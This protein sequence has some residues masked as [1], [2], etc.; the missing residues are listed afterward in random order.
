MRTILMS[1]LWLQFSCGPAGSDFYCPSCPCEND[2]RKHW[3]LHQT[4]Q[5][6]FQ[7]FPT[8]LPKVLPLL[9]TNLTR[10]KNLPKKSNRAAT[11]KRN[12]PLILTSSGIFSHFVWRSSIECRANEKFRWENVEGMVEC[13]KVRRSWE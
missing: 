3:I 13:T 12:L 8:H 7:N 11:L 1:A 4:V 5:I 2:T 6:S 9:T 10:T